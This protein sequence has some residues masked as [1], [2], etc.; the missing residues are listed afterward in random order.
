MSILQARPASSSCAVGGSQPVGWPSSPEPQ[1]FGR[2][3]GASV[4]LVGP[5][6]IKSPQE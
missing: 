2:A 1:S 3:G 4:V 5:L 6:L